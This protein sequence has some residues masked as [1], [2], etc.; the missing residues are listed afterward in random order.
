MTKQSILPS[1]IANFEYYLR[2]VPLYLQNSYGFVEHFR[3]WFNLLTGTKSDGTKTNLFQGV[4]PV[5]DTILDLMDLFS[6]TFLTKIRDFSDSGSS[7]SSDYGSISDILDKIGSLFGM[8]RTLS[9]SYIPIG[10]QS[11][12]S[13]EITLNN[14]DF[15]ILILAQIIRNYC[16]GTREQIQEYYDSVNLMVLSLD[17]DISANVESYL[18]LGSIVNYSDNVIKLWLSGLLTID[19]VG[20]KYLKMVQ[21]FST[22][23]IWDSSNWDTGEWT[24]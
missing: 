8:Q 24:I 15:R 21:N 7:S 3:I 14:E 22:L 19:S 6:D 16:E 20:V 4:V 13:E 5:A 2:K 9:I 23:G 11:Q 18:L 10:Q 12:I 1:E 17:T